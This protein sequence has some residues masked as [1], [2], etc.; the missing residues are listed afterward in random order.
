MT[1][2]SLTSG[3]DLLV[4][5]TENA[6]NHY[7]STWD[8]KP[9]SVNLRTNSDAPIQRSFALDISSQALQFHTGD[10]T[11]ILRFGIKGKVSEDGE[12]KHN[13]S[14]YTLEMKALVAHI[15]GDTSSSSENN[16]TFRGGSSHPDFSLTFHFGNK[17]AEWKI[18]SPEKEFSDDTKSYTDTLC[19]LLQDISINWTIG[20]TVPETDPIEKNLA[21]YLQPKSFILGSTKGFVNIYIQYTGQPGQQ[22]EKVNTPSSSN[23]DAH[24]VISH[25]LFAD[26]FDHWFRQKAPVSSV[27]LQ[28]TNTG[29]KFKI[30]SANPPVSVEDVWGF[31]DQIKDYRDDWT[32][33]AITSAP[34]TFN[35]LGNSLHISNSMSSSVPSVQVSRLFDANVDWWYAGRGKRLCGRTHFFNDTVET[36]SLSFE[37]TKLSLNLSYHGPRNLSPVKHEPVSIKGHNGYIPTTNESDIPN[38]ILDPPNPRW[39]YSN[40]EI[41]GL[42][43]IFKQNLFSSQL[44]GLACSAIHVPH[45]VVLSMKTDS[46][47]T[48]SST[49]SSRFDVASFVQ[50]FRNDVF[51]TKVINLIAANKKDDLRSLLKE[52]GYEHPPVTWKND[53]KAMTVPGDRFDLRVAG[54]LYK[55]VDP[56]SSVFK[57]L[58][59]D[60]KWG[61]I[62]VDDQRV[63]DQSVYA[64]GHVKI[65]IPKNHKKLDLIFKCDFDPILNGTALVGRNSFRGTTADQVKIEG[66][67]IFPWNDLNSPSVKAIKAA[68]LDD[69]KHVERLALK[70]FPLCLDLIGA[71]SEAE[72]PTDEIDLY[73]EPTTTTSTIGA[74]G[75]VGIVNN[76]MSMLDR[77]NVEFRVRGWLWQIRQRLRNMMLGPLN[78]EKLERLGISPSLIKNEFERVVK[79]KII[80]NMNRLEKEHPGMAGN[81]S[82]AAEKAS[83]EMVR[84]ME[85][86]CSPLVEEFFNKNVKAGWDGLTTKEK[87]GVRKSIRTVLQR[88]VFAGEKYNSYMK[89]KAQRIA[90]EHSHKRIPED[91]VKLQEEHEKADAE[92]Q[93]LRGEIAGLRAQQRTA[94]DKMSSGSAEDRKKLEQEINDIKDRLDLQE[95]SLNSLREEDARIKQE[96]E[97]KNHARFDD[98]TLEKLKDN[99]LHLKNRFWR[100]K[101]KP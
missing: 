70:H 86:F 17:K 43:A 9:S 29:V 42:D 93:K 90:E 81:T 39:P 75:V 92:M 26:V 46:M 34:V 54:G 48:F 44:G 77:P 64:S 36:A 89:A 23:G 24:I 76:C 22:P 25:R 40:T 67:Q 58:F 82:Q 100:S 69:L 63:H 79:S 14:G 65:T 30:E 56:H 50:L 71:S 84:H 66:A 101:P 7:L 8:A 97:K 4:S 2:Q 80:D 52:K 38:A 11:A 83:E 35:A 5:Y 31:K 20:F 41:T 61:H 95:K 47:A 51:L 33:H 78:L 60:S 55:N 32:V 3:W 98:T 72:R 1:N 88:D 49:S 13:L 94:M 62:Y 68:K 28:D 59:V 53:I 19:N 87:K 6:I 21:L 96:Q 37:S 57:E 91:L 10:D 18:L 73:V 12:E 15:T 74:V 16:I 85:E 99:E 45:D 27:K